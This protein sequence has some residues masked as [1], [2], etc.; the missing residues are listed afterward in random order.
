MPVGEAV[1]VQAV[2][3]EE[4]QAGRFVAGFDGADEVPPRRQRRMRRLGF[5]DAACVGAA[6]PAAGG[7]DPR[8]E[9]V[10]ATAEV[11]E[12][13]IESF[14]ETLTALKDPV[15]ALV[16][17]FS[18]VTSVRFLVPEVVDTF[19]SPSAVTVLMLMDPLL[20]FSV[21]SPRTLVSSIEIPPEV[22]DAVIPLPSESSICIEPEV[23]ARFIFPSDTISC[24]EI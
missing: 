6:R 10:V 17:M 22:L 14:A 21:M 3:V 2:G 4:P 20:Q 1:Q 23:L 11:A 19:M 15:V 24:T 8:E 18:A 13:E 16:V 9:R 5:G 12:A 7:E